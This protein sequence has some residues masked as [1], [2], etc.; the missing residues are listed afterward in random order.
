MSVRFPDDSRISLSVY[1]D[2]HQGGEFTETDVRRLDSL[3]PY[4]L[5]AVMY[6]RLWQN[7]PRGH[8]DVAV[9]TEERSQP[10]LLILEDGTVRPLNDAGDRYLSS[11]RGAAVS[12]AELTGGGGRGSRFETPAHLFDAVMLPGGSRLPRNARVALATEDRRQRLQEMFG[13]TCREVDVTIE[14]LEGLSNR[15]VA[16]RLGIAVET[17]RSYVK[18]VRHK[19]GFGSTRRLIAA[20]RE[21]L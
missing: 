5:N 6:R 11:Q 17:C 1:R 2:D 8:E 13:L 20:L 7:Q 12:G 14:L 19:S 4:L 18:N 3:R 15:E 10:A 21:I 9:A 16:D